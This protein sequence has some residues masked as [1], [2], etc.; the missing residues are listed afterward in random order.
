MEMCRILKGTA[1]ME[2]HGGI[3]VATIV[4]EAALPAAEHSN[5]RVPVAR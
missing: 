5:V 2:E 3:P 1:T 4:M